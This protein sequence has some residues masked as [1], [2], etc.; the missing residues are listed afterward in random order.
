VTYWAG[1]GGTSAKLNV[2]GA[3][4]KST[5]SPTRVLLNI[6]G[7]IKPGQTHI[8]ATFRSTNFQPGDFIPT[9]PGIFTVLPNALMFRL[10]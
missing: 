1:P 7:L 2:G 3:F 5:A 8:L 9:L 6:G 10:S 4:L